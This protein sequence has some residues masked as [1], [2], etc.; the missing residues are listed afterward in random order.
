M[1]D[2]RITRH[3]ECRMR[4]R[5]FK[6][7]DV[8]LIMSSSTQVAED[9]FFLTNEDVAREIVKRKTEIQQLER[10]RGSKAIVAEGK[11]ITIYRSP[12]NHKQRKG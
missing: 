9:A 5:G 2:L 11:L 7:I 10:L 12:A 8:E 3:A 4:Q 1:F 6:A